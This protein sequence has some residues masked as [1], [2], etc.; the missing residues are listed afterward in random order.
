MPRKRYLKPLNKEEL[1]V[2]EWLIHHRGIQT[3]IAVR[4][5]CS[6]QFVQQVCYGHDTAT[7]ARKPIEDE[8]R[9]AGWPG[10]TRKKKKDLTI[11]R[12]IE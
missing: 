8:L 12:G 10:I 11:Y 2:K 3:Q 1:A 5:Q 4:L 7:V 6:P 9:A